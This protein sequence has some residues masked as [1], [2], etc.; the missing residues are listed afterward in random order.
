MR[1]RSLHRLLGMA[2]P[3]GQR[4]ALQPD[5]RDQRVVVGDRR[6]HLQGVLEMAPALQDVRRQQPRRR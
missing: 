5:H 4:G 6:E 2:Q 1:C 3:L